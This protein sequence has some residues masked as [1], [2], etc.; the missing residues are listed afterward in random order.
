MMKQ[1]LHDNPN[2]RGPIDTDAWAASI[3]VCPA[4]RLNTEGWTAEEW[5]EYL[6]QC[7]THIVVVYDPPEKE[8]RYAGL[9]MLAVWLATVFTLVALTYKLTGPGS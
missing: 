8:T 4:A 3:N 1:T 5:D 2:M 9:L 7:N 6:G